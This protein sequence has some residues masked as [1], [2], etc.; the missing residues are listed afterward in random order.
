MCG[1][2]LGE[3]ALLR[4][5]GANGEKGFPASREETPLQELRGDGGRG[6]SGAGTAAFWGGPWGG[7]SQP[8]GGERRDLR[9]RLEGNR[10]TEEVSAGRGAETGAGAL[11][12]DR[13]QEGNDTAPEG[14]AGL[15][16]DFRG[17]E[18][19]CMGGL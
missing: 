7:G 5:E 11:R 8:P 14:S 2:S 18:R 6:A 12:G 13:G 15:G 19:V 3:G 16:K 9:W 4:R 10:G 1:C 17:V